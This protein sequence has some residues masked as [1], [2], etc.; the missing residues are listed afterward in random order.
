M[1]YSVKLENDEWYIRE[2]DVE[3]SSCGLYLPGGTDTTA[4]REGAGGGRK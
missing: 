3:I 1:S 4:R 2:R